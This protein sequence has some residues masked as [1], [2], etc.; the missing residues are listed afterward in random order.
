MKEKDRKTE[1]QRDRKIE[2]EIERERDRS[3]EGERE[4][5]KFS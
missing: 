5:L 4:S 2:G 1:R 3:T